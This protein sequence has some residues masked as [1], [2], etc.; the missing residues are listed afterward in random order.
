MPQAFLHLSDGEI[1]SLDDSMGTESHLAAPPPS[2]ALLLEAAHIENVG[3]LGRI[4]PK[5]VLD[6]SFPLQTKVRGSDPP[7]RPVFSQ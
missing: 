1:E 3:L 5:T 4:S 7:P 6:K 2:P